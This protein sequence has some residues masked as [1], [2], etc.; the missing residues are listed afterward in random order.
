MSNQSEVQLKLAKQGVYAPVLW[1]INENAKK[2][3]KFSEKVSEN[4][5]SLPIDQRY[6]PDDM[7]LIYECLKQAVYD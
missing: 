4:M 7:D 3:C 1:P 5:L 2:V 6:S